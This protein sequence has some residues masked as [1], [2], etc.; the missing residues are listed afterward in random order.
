MK[1]T[2][3]TKADIR[4]KQFKFLKHMLICSN[5]KA[6]EPKPGQYL[7]IDETVGKAITDL[8]LNVYNQTVQQYL[9]YR[10]KHNMA[11]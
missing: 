6:T 8:V 1:I 7:S 2:A 4:R 11:K 10:L 5:M 9:N 3:A